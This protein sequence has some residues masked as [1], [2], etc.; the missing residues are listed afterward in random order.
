MTNNRPSSPCHHHC[1]RSNDAVLLTSRV[2]PIS[3]VIHGTK[4][5]PLDT[6]PFQAEENVFNSLHYYCGTIVNF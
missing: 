4:C 6:R 3:G 5:S 1:D 2:V